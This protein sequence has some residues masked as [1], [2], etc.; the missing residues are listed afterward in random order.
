M[1][2]KVF[3][4]ERE[5]A[6]ARCAYHEASTNESASQLNDR[7]TAIKKLV[8]ELSDAYTKGAVDRPEGVKSVGMKRRPGLYE[9]GNGEIRSQ[10]ETPDEAV[11]NWNDGIFVAAQGVTVTKG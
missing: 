9:V 4:I 2:K 3:E 1:A 7:A 8:G 11:Q 6:E 10:G 5:L